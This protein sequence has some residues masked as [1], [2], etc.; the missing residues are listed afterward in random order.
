MDL[1]KR[2]ARKTGGEGILKTGQDEISPKTA[3]KKKKIHKENKPK[4]G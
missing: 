2:K 1:R 4:K 3:V